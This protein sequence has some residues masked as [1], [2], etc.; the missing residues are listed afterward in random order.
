VRRNGPTE[1][2][3]LM[4]PTRPGQAEQ[5]PHAAG[6]RCYAPGGAWIV[7]ES[8]PATQGRPASS[9]QQAG[10]GTAGRCSSGR[11]R[12]H[13]WRIAGRGLVTGGFLLCGW[14]VTS[15][16][17]AD[18]A[19]TATP[20]A[21]HDLVSA[22]SQITGSGVSRH[23]LSSAA[24]L[25]GTPY[26]GSQRPAP[27]LPAVPRFPGRAGAGAGNQG[28]HTRPA[29]VSAATGRLAGTLASAVTIV[30]SPPGRAPASAVAPA[31]PA[32][33]RPALVIAAAPP[34][35]VS[36]T[37]VAPPLAGRPGDAVSAQTAASGLT[38]AIRS[39]VASLATPLLQ[40]LGG[41]AA[42]GLVPKTLALPS[43]ASGP[44]AGIPGASD[45]TSIVPAG[46]NPGGVNLPAGI[47]PGSHPLMRMASRPAG[48][49]ARTARPAVTD[50]TMAPVPAAAA[51]Q[52]ASWARRA[53][54]QY[55]GA[56]QP[57][58]PHPATPGGGKL[59]TG[60]ATQTDPTAPAG[61][62]G[63]AQMAAQMPSR[64]GQPNPAGWLVRMRTSRSPGGL[65]RADDPAVSPD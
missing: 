41:P 36:S 18:A 31:R 47:L 65:Q 9:R 38:S 55:A 1:P 63:A 24:S 44:V 21:P 23:A 5:P 45:V 27:A 58:V 26:R 22:A 10:D 60:A 6:A 28:S 54:R 64:S 43:L 34:A 35:A 57:G 7:P 53:P 32:A 39:T 50:A 37:P 8:R 51:Q 59:G 3:R 33:A 46:V 25:L 42:G 61:G 11:T 16:G 62:S 52:A 29:A 13:G 48:G 14:L 40:S 19:V 20:A 30:T 2:Y 4:G 17:H 15:A 12:G 56:Q 49:P